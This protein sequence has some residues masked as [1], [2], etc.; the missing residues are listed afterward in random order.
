MQIL[1]G[2]ESG[3]RNDDVFLGG[4]SGADVV[5][6]RAHAVAFDRLP[7]VFFQCI[8]QQ[9]SGVKR[10]EIQRRS[11]EDAED[12]TDEMLDRFGDLPRSVTNLFS[13]ALLRASAERT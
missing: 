10:R 12:L 4:G 8:R 6:T 3:R 13:V 11:A 2:G 1:R 7:A 9:S 5:E